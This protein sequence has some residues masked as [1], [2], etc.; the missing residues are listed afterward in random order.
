MMKKIKKSLYLIIPLVFL[1]G[2]YASIAFASLELN[3]LLWPESA[4]LSLIFWGLIVIICG[5][6]VAAMINE[7]TL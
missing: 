5:V 2:L 7:K 1:A 6:L 4:R 3:A